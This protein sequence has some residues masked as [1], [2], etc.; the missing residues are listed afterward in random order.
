MKN[1]VITGANGFIA[2]NVISIL[3]LNYDYN[4]IKINFIKNN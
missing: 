2:K 4:L 3:S 1:I